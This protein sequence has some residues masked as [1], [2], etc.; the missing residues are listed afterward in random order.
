M[1]LLKQ[2]RGH[3]DP[4]FEENILPWVS[5]RI[6]LLFESGL[7]KVLRRY[8]YEDVFTMFRYPAGTTEPLMGNSSD[9]KYLDLV[10]AILD[11][12]FER[13]DYRVP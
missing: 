4:S 10:K 9:G 7:R 2:A 1:G 11:E 6:H 8:L 3:F 13:R 12:V 5:T